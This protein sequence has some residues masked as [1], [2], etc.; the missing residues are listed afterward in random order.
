MY[1]IISNVKEAF[2]KMAKT[3]RNKFLLLKRSILS[4]HVFNKKN[5]KKVGAKAAISSVKASRTRTAQPQRAR[6]YSAHKINNKRF[7]VVVAIAVVAIMVP[8]MV[9]AANGDTAKPQDTTT[10]AA[11]A[12]QAADATPAA[13]AAAAP[14][15]TPAAAAAEPT[16]PPAPTPAPTPQYVTLLAGENNPAV[17]AL[18][19]RL[20]ELHYMS[21][22]QATDYFGPATLRAV[23]AFQ[24]KHGLEVDGAAG[25][26]TQAIL[27]SDAAK[28]YTAA[29]NADG[30]DVSL[31]QERLLNLGYDVSVTGHFGEMT[32]KAVKYFQRMNGLTDDG[33]VGSQTMDMLFSD[34]AEESEEKKAADKKKEEDAKK[35]SSG[36]K[37]GTSGKKPSGNK[38]SSGGGGGGSA[39]AANP[40][41][42]EAF[43]DAAMAQVGKPYVLGG[44]G[45][46]SFDCSGFVYYALQQSGNGIGYMTSGGWAG[47][48]YAS[49]GWDNMQR[50]DIV[51][52]SGHVGIY[53]GGGSIVD[54]SSGSGQI[55]VRG[56]GSWFRD[57]FI[58]AKRPL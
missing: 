34:N 22:D 40:G 15:E 19:D 43:I 4:M 42:V 58:C 1:H 5:V 45:P 7:T 55:V 33:S 51:C 53:L 31:I 57:R 32:E 56:M 47:S 48:G 21:Q 2:S 52:V 23:Q 14:T 54:A 8:V 13:V 6:K 17:P 35:K 29:L 16:A 46:D 10:T 28:E 27:F 18:Q 20:M 3:L 38:G 9:M 49:V 39:A 24:R 30:D 37:S 50:G 41:S 11:A 44:K 26:E 25:A 12:Q 36:K